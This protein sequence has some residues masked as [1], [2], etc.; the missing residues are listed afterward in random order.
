MTSFVG[1]SGG[2]SQVA[3]TVVT[4]YTLKTYTLN[5]YNVI[6]QYSGTGKSPSTPQDFANLVQA[7][8]FFQ[9][10]K[11]DTAVSLPSGVT[12]NGK[13]T[14]DF[15][16]Y[17]GTDFGAKLSGQVDALLKTFDQVNIENPD[18]DAK[19]DL[20]V[21]LNGN[22][23]TLFDLLSN[24]NASFS[25]SCSGDTLTDTN[26]SD[27]VGGD[28]DTLKRDWF[29]S[30]GGDCNGSPGLSVHWH[31][32]A[33]SSSNHVTITATASA[34]ENCAKITASNPAASKDDLDAIEKT[35]GNL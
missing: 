17:A 19:Y 25:A 24:P 3:T 4:A 15:S 29:G 23:I 20:P 14:V 13:S 27:N 22:S 1:S 10:M 30:D 2:I 5:E 8:Q 26:Y 33:C 21:T 6:A 12:V 28:H 11:N 31:A 9:A 34:I 18:D 35:L 7:Y 32:D 16:I